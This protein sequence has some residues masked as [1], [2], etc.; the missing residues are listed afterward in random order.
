[1]IYRSCFGEFY[2]DN[3]VPML[4]FASRISTLEYLLSRTFH[5]LAI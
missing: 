2:F 1:M 5:F 4:N 3:E